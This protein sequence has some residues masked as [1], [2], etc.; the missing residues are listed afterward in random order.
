MSILNSNLFIFLNNSYVV[1]FNKIGNIKK[2]NKLPDKLGTF[3]IF[4]SKSIMY[5]NKKNKLVVVN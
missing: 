5:L 3:P 1:Q 4:I 2:I